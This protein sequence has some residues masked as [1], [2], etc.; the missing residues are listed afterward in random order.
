MSNN[1]ILLSVCVPTYNQPSAVQILLEKLLPQ[2]LSKIEILVCDD[3]ENGDTKKII[4]QFSSVAPIRYFHGKKEGL[5]SAIL[6]LTEEARGQF[7]WWFGDDFIE[8]SAIQRIIS[9]IEEFQDLT[10]I[11]V[12]SHDISNKDALTINDRRSYFFPDKNKILEMDIGLLGFITATIFKREVAITGIEQAR[13]H[14]G[15]AFVCMYIVLYVIAR[16]GR[17]YFLGTPCFMSNSKPSGEVRWYDQFQVF[18]INIFNI[19]NEFKENFNKRQIR[20][21]LSKNLALVIK[22][23]IVERSL[24]LNTGFASS[25]P[26]LLPLARLYWSYWFFWIALPLLVL[27]NFILSVLYSIFKW[28]KYKS[29]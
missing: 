17:Y 15:S 7:V 22:A 21:S 24:G 10:F 26:K 13:K 19:V 8:P 20:K 2:Y 12:N 18:G 25:S 23:I 4:D 6:F 28:H 29:K 9:L 1:E 3:S 16:G 5:D 11:W 14:V 27:P